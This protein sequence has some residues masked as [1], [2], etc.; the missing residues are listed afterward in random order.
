MRSD[1]VE[2]FIQRTAHT[3][4]VG[5]RLTSPDLDLCAVGCGERCAVGCGKSVYT[6]HTMSSV[7]ALLSVRFCINEA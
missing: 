3:C 4:A 5:L 7:S 1:A 6:A 2:V